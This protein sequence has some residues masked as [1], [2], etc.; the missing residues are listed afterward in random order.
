MSNEDHP[1]TL[2]AKKVRDGDILAGPHVRNA[3]NRHLKDLERDDIIFHVESA[4]RVINFFKHLL[5][6]STGQFHGDPFIMDLSQKFIF[7]SI[8]GWK[9]SDNIEVRRFQ[10]AYIEEP[11][12]TGKTPAAAGCAIYCGLADGEQAP[13]VYIAA[14]TKIQAG[15]CFSDI[16]RMIDNSPD[17]KKRV[18][19]V[20]KT[21]VEEILVPFNNGRI[22][23]VSTAMGDRG[24]GLRP[25][26]IIADEVHEWKNSNLLDTLELGFKSRVNPLIVMITNSGISEEGNMCW[27]QHNYSIQVANGTITDD[28][29]FS[30]VCG[31]DEDEDPLSTSITDEERERLYRKVTPLYGQIITKG[32]LDKRVHEAQNIPGRASKVLR[33]NFCKWVQSEQGWI[34][35]D[36]WSK[37]ETESIIFEDLGEGAELS[38]GLDLS[39]TLDFTAVAFTIKDGDKYRSWVEIYTPSGSLQEREDRDKAPYNEWYRQGYLKTTPGNK[40]QYAYVA[41][42]I[43]EVVDRFE[44]IK[45]LAYDSWSFD[46]FETE[47]SDIGLSRLAIA[48]P[49]GTNKSRQ[50]GLFMPSSIEAFEGLIAEEKFKVEYNPLLRQAVSGSIQIINNSGLKRWGKGMKNARI[51]PLVALT[52]SIGLATSDINLGYSSPFNEE[53]GWEKWLEDIGYKL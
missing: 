24:S 10:R 44:N 1:V 51:D 52:M 49:Q 11:K 45:G 13:E 2:Y 4:D 20:G 53:G 30:Y 36:L 34:T 7:G 32:Y 5:R 12:G 35:L 43:K 6:H 39:N 8:F 37:C 21:S 41:R 38:I 16:K 27:E 26:T 19:A 23:L 28:N 31:L 25:S 17:I 42:A 50:S 33:W 47:L 15:V 22:L 18:Q 29:T 9:K 46:R 3:C 40:V 48:H 14:T